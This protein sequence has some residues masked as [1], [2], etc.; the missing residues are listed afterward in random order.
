[1]EQFAGK[2]IQVVDDQES[3]AT[4]NDA[5]TGTTTDS[6]SSEIVFDALCFEVEVYSFTNSLEI[7]LVNDAGDDQGPLTVPK[8]GFR[9]WEFRARGFKIKS[10]VAGSAADYEVVAYFKN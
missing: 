7:V 6:W 9:S 2:R 3:V 10:K 8:N 1:M 5:K 4:A